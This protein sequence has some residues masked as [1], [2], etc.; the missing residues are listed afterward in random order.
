MSKWIVIPKWEDFQHY[1]DRD[2]IW[3]KS[4]TRLLDDDDYLGLAP[5]T[6]AVLHGLWLAYARSDCQLRA[7]TRSLSSRLALRVTSQQLKALKQAGFIRLVA[8][9][10]LAQRYQA[11]SPEKEAEKEASEQ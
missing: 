3:V 1:K 6:R 10:P 8:S 4:Y 2:P 9:K 5:G 7:D 11:A